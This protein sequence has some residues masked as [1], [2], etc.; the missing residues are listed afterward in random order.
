MKLITLIPLAALAFAA[1]D[2]KQDEARKAELDAKATK[3]DEAAKA[4]KK[5][6]NADAKVIKKEGE[7]KA[8]ALK[9]EAN[10]VR[11]QKSGN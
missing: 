3:L 7:A 5:D 4:E 11:D 8:E 6:A 2:S 1:C 10:R 9:D